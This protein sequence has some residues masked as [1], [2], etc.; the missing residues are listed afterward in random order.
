MK[1]D[2]QPNLTAT[3]YIQHVDD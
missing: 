1:R 2:F 3:S